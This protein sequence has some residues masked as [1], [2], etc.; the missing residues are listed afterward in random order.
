MK[1]FHSICGWRCDLRHSED[2]GNKKRR[3]IFGQFLSRFYA[4]LTVT[5]Y[6]ASSRGSCGIRDE[7]SGL[8]VKTDDFQVYEMSQKGCFKK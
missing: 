5:G 8:G 2:N 3:I 6:V 1:N 4:S 7:A